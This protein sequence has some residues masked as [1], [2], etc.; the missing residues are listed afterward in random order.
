MEE[1]T[2][3][4]QRDGKVY[5]T[6]QIGEQVWMAENL[7]FEAIGSVCYE[8][9]PAN[10]K[11]Y[12]R[13]YNWETAMK[14]CPKGWH[15]PSDEEWSML[16]AFAGG[17][18][19]AGN[20]L[21]ASS[22]WNENGNG[23]DEFGFAALPGGNGLR[24]GG[25]FRNVGDDGNWW[26]AT[27]YSVSCA[28]YRNI[29]FCLANVDRLD[30]GKGYLFSVRCVKDCYNDGTSAT[31]VERKYTEAEAAAKADAQARSTGTEKG[32]FTDQRDG[33]VYKTVQIG[34]Q[35][36]MAENLNFEVIGSVCYENDPA[37]GQ[38]YGRLYNWETAKIACP[39]GWHLPSKEEWEVLTAAVG[40][41]SLKAA[42]GWKTNN[43]TDAFGFAA[44]P[45]GFGSSGGNFKD[46]GSSG[47]WWSASERSANYVYYA[48]YQTMSNNSKHA[49]WRDTEDKHNLYSV[50]CLQD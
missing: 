43:D 40:G 18:D 20:I 4:D 49:S 19:V 23:T 14:A 48:Y 9:D 15:L 3:T 6:V 2:F 22:G 36:W 16:F 1:N 25:S 33:K 45:G 17:D 27:K 13:L 12:G 28:C 34:E 35:V 24:Y 10:G 31:F 32:T 7:N 11:K 47:F 26:S 44:L 46:V 39:K 42:S 8:N 30:D 41:E 21:K 38:K 29:H 50:R 5:K 37:N